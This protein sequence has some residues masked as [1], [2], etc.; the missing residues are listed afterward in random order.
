MDDV[1][2][3]TGVN[4]Q[5]KADNEI[6]DD[7]EKLLVLPLGDESKKITQVIS[8]DTA[9]KI[10]EL[11][12]GQSMSA[13]DI[14]K[15]LDVPLTT[16]KYNLEN[17]VDV[18]LVKIERIKYSEKGREVKVYAPVRKL[19]VVVPEKLGST[20]I[21]EVLKKYLGVILTAF[22]ASGFVEL[23]TSKFTSSNSM[24]PDGNAQRIFEEGSS[25]DSSMDLVG[26]FSE[27]T[28]DTIIGVVNDSAQKTLSNA[29]AP[30]ATN[31]AEAVPEATEIATDMPS[32][33]P[34]MY[35]EPATL[36]KGVSTFDLDFTSHL[37]LWFL[38]GC[39]FMIA[40]VMIVD[41]YRQKKGANRK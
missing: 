6:N 36:E 9:R 8:N 38:M 34:T 37:G 17:L 41:Y 27:V 30:D 12:A 23:L 25:M 16:I 14:A 20:S 15:Q 22:F 40:L 24:M 13:S 26:N 33:I 1:R 7:S 35:I 28:E 21:T 19:I 31:I 3:D 11:L 5:D 39:L 10:M 4:S 29:T 18:G 2:G 32:H